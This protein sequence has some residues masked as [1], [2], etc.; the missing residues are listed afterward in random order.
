MKMYLFR[1]SCKSVKNRIFRRRKMRLFRDLFP[2]LKRHVK[3]PKRETHESVSRFG[4]L[5]YPIRNPVYPAAEEFLSV[6]AA[7]R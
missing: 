7:R 4:F 3:I 6:K 5:A 2:V 1:R